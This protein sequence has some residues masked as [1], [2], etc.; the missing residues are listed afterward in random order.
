MAGAHTFDLADAMQ[1]YSN[2]PEGG[3]FFFD[4]IHP[5]PRGADK[6]AELVRPVIKEVLEGQKKE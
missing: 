2:G 3:S 6:F 4:S 1:P 5:T